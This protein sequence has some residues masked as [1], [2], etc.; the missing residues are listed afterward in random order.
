MAVLAKA[1]EAEIEGAWNSLPERAAYRCVRPPETGLVMTRGRIGGSGAAFNLG[2]ITVTRCVV[3]LAAGG[4][5]GFSYVTGRDLRH[6]ELAA[7]FD[8]MLQRP[9]GDKVRP[10]L[11]RLAEAYERRRR[12]AAG[13][14]AATKVEFFTMVRE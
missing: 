2:E 3:E 8:A 14:A 6:A 4:A 7:A 11:D 13:E 10:A 12:I 1:S 5:W 9:D